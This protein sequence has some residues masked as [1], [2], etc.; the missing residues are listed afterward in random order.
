MHAVTFPLQ[1]LPGPEETPARNRAAKFPVKN[2]TGKYNNNNLIFKEKLIDRLDSSYICNV[3]IVYYLFI[4]I[5]SIGLG[6]TNPSPLHLYNLYQTKDNCKTHTQK[7]GNLDDELLFKFV[8]IGIE[9]PDFQVL[10]SY[11][12]IDLFIYISHYLFNYSAKK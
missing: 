12:I 2:Q 6:P 3:L 10:R 9:F 11:F 5:G 7:Q 4:I 8:Q 1:H